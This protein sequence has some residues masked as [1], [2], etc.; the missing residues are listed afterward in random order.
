MSA[1]MPARL[2]GILHDYDKNKAGPLWGTG[3]MCQYLRRLEVRVDLGPVL[4]CRDDAEGDD[5][6]T[7]LAEV[8][9]A[10]L[11]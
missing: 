2:S 8:L 6:L 7:H 1:D 3:L 10:L 5:L 4:D 11:E 9:V